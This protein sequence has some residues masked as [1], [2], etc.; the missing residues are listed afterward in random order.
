M[1]KRVCNTRVGAC[2]MLLAVFLLV[3][4]AGAP[5]FARVDVS[6]GQAG[7]PGDGLD[8]SSGSGGS[9]DDGSEPSSAPTAGMRLL[10]FSRLSIVLVPIF[11]G[12]IMHFIVII[13]CNRTAEIVK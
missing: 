8:F 10:D 4:G 11:D 12:T 5:A 6:V 2:V 13:N 9:Q 7:D 1:M 3:G